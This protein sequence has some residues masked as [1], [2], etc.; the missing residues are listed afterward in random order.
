M[1]DQPFIPSMANA[2]QVPCPHIED[3]TPAPEGYFQWHAWAKDMAKT[4]RSRR[5]PGCNLYNIW[6]PK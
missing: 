4:H 3:H 2:A 6:E 5:C 1:T